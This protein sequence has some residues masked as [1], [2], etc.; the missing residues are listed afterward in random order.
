MCLDVWESSAIG[1]GT[2]TAHTNAT[3]VVL[4]VVGCLRAERTAIE[5]RLR[6]V[7]AG[8]AEDKSGRERGRHK[9]R[10]GR[11]GRAQR[12]ERPK[13]ARAMEAGS[14]GRNC[15]VRGDRTAPSFIFL[16]L[17]EVLVLVVVIVVRAAFVLVLLLVQLC[18]RLV[19]TGKV[20]L[21]A[22]DAADATEALAELRTLL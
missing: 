8:I 15:A 1:S 6:E 11:G 14:A 22:K 18:S 12:R 5:Y 10:V 21:I 2:N 20:H 4:C 9:N 7:G 19:Q 3:G 13:R 17:D 16:F